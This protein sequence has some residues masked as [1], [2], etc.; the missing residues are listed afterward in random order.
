[1][2]LVKVSLPVFGVST[3]ILFNSL[4]GEGVYNLLDRMFL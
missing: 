3:R 4:K 1:M 2:V